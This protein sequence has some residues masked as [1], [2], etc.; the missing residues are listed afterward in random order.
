MD[1]SCALFLRRIEF[2]AVIG[3]VAGGLHA[4]VRREGRGG[5]ARGT[6]GVGRAGTIG[7]ENA[8]RQG[9]AE[10]VSVWPRSQSPIAAGDRLQ[11]AAIFDF[12]NL[13]HSRISI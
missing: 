1:L 5:I 9:V 11:P 7:G 13:G 10:R 3:K 6:G 2:A 12:S 8:E 4:E